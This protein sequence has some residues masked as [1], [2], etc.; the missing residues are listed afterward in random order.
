M[1]RS[2]GSVAKGTSPVWWH[3]RDVRF[4]LLAPLQGA[5]AQVVGKN[6]RK[7]VWNEAG[8]LSGSRL[9]TGGNHGEIQKSEESE[10]FDFSRVLQ[11]NMK[12]AKGN[13]K[14]LGKCLEQ[15]SNLI[16]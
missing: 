7:G 9:E 6:R 16:E 14:L 15:N 13:L 2:Y 10:L 11:Q 12:K 1:L 8:W 5:G 3:L 4:A